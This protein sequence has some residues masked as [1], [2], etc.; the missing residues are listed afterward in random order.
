LAK[1]VQAAVQS[2]IDD[3]TYMKILSTWG[4]VDGAIQTSQINPNVG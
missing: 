1:S 3:G 4:V 2:L